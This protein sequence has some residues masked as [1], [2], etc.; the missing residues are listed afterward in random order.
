MPA[1]RRFFCVALYSLPLL[2]ITALQPFATASRA[3]EPF[4]LDAALEG[5]ADREDWRS[6]SDIEFPRHPAE[7]FLEDWV[8]VLDPGHG[9]DAHRPG[10]KR[11]PT[12]AREADINWRV[13]VLLE[14][15]LMDSGAH[16]AMTRIGDHFVSL[17]D[18]AEIANTVRRPGGGAGADLFIS[19]HHNASGNPETNYTSVW[20]HGGVDWSEPDLDVARYAAHALFR[21]LRTDAGLTSYLMSD[22]QMYGGGFGVLRRTRVP[23]VLL[24][25]SFH[26]HPKEE[27][28]LRDSLHNLRE[29]YAVYI[30]LCEYAYGGRPT[31]S[32]PELQIEN[33]EISLVTDIDD[34]LPENWWGA[35]RNRTLTSTVRAFLDDEEVP[36]R[37]DPDGNRLTA[38]FPPPDNE[39][40]NTES[41]HILRIHHAN[42]SKNHNWPQRYLVTFSFDEDEAIA[43]TTVRPIGARR[44]APDPELDPDWEP[45]AEEEGPLPTPLKLPEGPEVAAAYQEAIAEARPGDVI[46]MEEPAKD[47]IPRLPIRITA[48]ESPQ[49]LLS[50]KPEYFRTGD[51]IAMQETVEPGLVRLYT[52]HVPASD[53]PAV[54]TSTLENIGD[55]PLN[56]RF[57]RDAFPEP[58]TH[59]IAIARE[60]MVRF[61]DGAVS[62]SDR[63]VKPDEIIAIDPRTEETEVEG[64]VLVHTWYEF[65]IDQPARISTFRRPVE[66]SSEEALE[67]LDTLPRILPGHRRSGAGRGLFSISNF[68]TTL[69]GNHTIDTAGGVQQIVVADGR[70]DRW[71][72]GRD[73]I[74]GEDEEAEVE[75][76][77]NYGAVYRIRVD[78][79]SSDGRSLAVMLHNPFTDDTFC[80]HMGAALRIDDGKFD[81]GTVKAPRETASFAGGDQS[82]LLQVFPPLPEG[83]RETIELEFT[84]PGASCLPAPIFFVPFEEGV[85]SP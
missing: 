69:A 70:E 54:I 26:T 45:P 82:V 40:G 55:E 31:Q 23:A 12:G 8:I 68:L 73:S 6:W 35:D 16:V 19:L 9:G 50:D 34:G 1:C 4:P 80:H 58:S 2:A 37:F 7:K 17:A 72:I 14:Q 85:A 51:G 3:S 5:L 81:G 25:S 47:D 20:F 65:E 44:T 77:G 78:R 39:T 21:K 29:A 71:M 22:H 36:S 57:H 63:T 52:Y 76:R 67:L 27:Q 61:F 28:R 84:P 62:L 43:G 24:E 18:R 66:M 11:G 79:T 41:R 10:Y 15:L 74:P 33:G 64:D 32:E 56:L 30:A 83:E 42:F 60:A 13:A 48:E 49:L 53:E 46:R 75:N 38:Q 59:Y